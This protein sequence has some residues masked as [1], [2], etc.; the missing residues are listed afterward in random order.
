MLVT[1]PVSHGVTSVA[2]NLVL[3][4]ALTLKNAFARGL[5]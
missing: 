1:E 2:A 4:E 5:G 3:A